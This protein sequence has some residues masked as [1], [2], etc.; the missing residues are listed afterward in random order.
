MIEDLS[1]FTLKHDVAKNN[2]RACRIEHPLNINL[3]FICG[4]CTLLIS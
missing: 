3:L 2:I 1:A 4:L